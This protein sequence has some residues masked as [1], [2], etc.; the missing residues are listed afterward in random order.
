MILQTDPKAAYLEHR[1]EIDE[2]VQRVLGSGW[3]IHGR[4]VRAFEE[5]FATYLGVKHAVAVASGTD[6][7]ELA[8]RACGI[9]PGDLVATVSH[10][11][12]ATVAAV[13]LAGATP[14]LVDVDPRTLT[15]DVAGLEEMFAGPEGQ[16]IRA[17]LPVHL[18]G[19]AADLPRIRGI[20]RRHGAILIEDCAQAHGALLEGARLGNWG[21]AAAFSFYP[22]K[23]LGALGDAGLVTTN[24][25]AVDKKLRA[26]RVHGSEVKY[27]HKFIGYNMR[28]D[29]VHAAVLRVKLPH[30]ATWLSAR[31]AAAKRYDSLIEGANLHGFM[32][33]PVLPVSRVA[34]PVCL[35]GLPGWLRAC[36]SPR[37]RRVRCRRRAARCRGSP[38]RTGIRSSRVCRR[39]GRVIRPCCASGRGTVRSSS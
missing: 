11:A 17:V 21:D 32:R 6:A 29:A 1:E 16:R 8:L 27:Y 9:G 34:V 20:C 28:L 26:L 23:N 24:D 2:A 31:E 39:S 3:Y 4:E 30:V 37:C 25:A 18:Y 13:E 22:T 36:R 10:T 14:F 38:R 7:L 5:E 33:R 15:L 35:R 12:V 19:Q